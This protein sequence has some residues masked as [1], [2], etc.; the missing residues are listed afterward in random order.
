MNTIQRP[1][2]MR[3]K[4][5]KFDRLQENKTENVKIPTWKMLTIYMRNM[6]LQL[7]M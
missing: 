3:R 6:T 5:G 4:D 1:T 7:A 2:L